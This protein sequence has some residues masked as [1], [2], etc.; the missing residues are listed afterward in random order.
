MRFRADGT[1]V[2]YT[3]LANVLGMYTEYCG[4]TSLSVVAW[5][6][7][8]G[9]GLRVA[10]AAGSPGPGTWSIAYRDNDPTFR[11]SIYYQDS[12][13]TGYIARPVVPEDASI[14]ISQ[15]TSNSIAGTFFG[16][17]KASGLPDVTITHG[18][19]SVRLEPDNQACD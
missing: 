1:L 15:V 19:F 2:E 14:T 17:V 9:L 5:D 12:R 13:G 4:A 16:L 10:S 3:A 18:E 11:M 8:S 7:A 6:L